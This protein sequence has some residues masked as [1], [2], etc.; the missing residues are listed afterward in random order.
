LRDPLET[1][2]VPVVKPRYWLLTAVAVFVVSV[3]LFPRAVAIVAVILALPV[4]IFLHEL[5][6]YATAK[7]S[8]MKVTEFFVGFGPRLWSVTKGETEYG[9]KAIPLGGY[10]KIIGMTNLEDVPPEDE[11]RTY[12]AKQYLPKVIVAGAG[13]AMHFT[14]AIL[15]M[16][17]VLVADGDRSKASLTTTIGFVEAGSPADQ[18]GLESGDEL[19]AIDGEPIDEWG[20]LR[21][22]LM[23]RGGETITFTV[24][25]DGAE[26]NLDV[27][28]DTI[29]NPEFDPNVA[30]SA[31]Q[32]GRAGVGASIHVPGVGPG[33]ALWLA[34]ARTAELGRD[35]LGALGDM[36]SLS[37]L[38]NYVDLLEGDENADETKRFLSP[39]GYGQVAVDVT[40]G[41]WVYV[42]ELLIALNVFV[43]LLNLFP[44][45]P[46]DGG[47]IAIATYEKVAST[48]TRRKVQVDV[49]KLLPAMGLVMAL[50]AVIFV[51]SL[52]LD[53]TRPI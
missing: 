18:A 14:L 48:I 52:F 9:L 8:G 5:A 7:R 4:I 10:C 35:S 43:G 46:F 39:V 27:T 31:E 13:S 12:R 3:F 22:S 28:V 49:A 29:D 50:L 44:M 11:P 40:E 42:F 17:V 25:R 20:D 38:S 33:Q 26:E 30:G 21:Q 47:H 19:V 24:L 16:F 41:G 32:I 15:L 34:P 1:I 36:F 51:S 2:D 23:G 45:L 37:G 53:L 6:H